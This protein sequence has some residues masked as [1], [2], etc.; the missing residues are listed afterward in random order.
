MLFDLLHT[1]LNVTLKCVGLLVL[2]QMVMA[3]KR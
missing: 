1:M 3:L 2:P